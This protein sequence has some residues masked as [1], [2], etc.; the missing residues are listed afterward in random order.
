MYV[1]GPF[2]VVARKAN[3]YFTKLIFLD[4]VRKIMA[5]N[6]KGHDM[7]TSI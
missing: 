7:N 3:V 4:A 1:Y 2:C 6:A 5:P